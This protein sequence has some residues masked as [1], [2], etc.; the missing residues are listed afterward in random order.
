MRAFACDT[1]ENLLFFENT[2]CLRCGHQQRFAVPRMRLVALAAESGGTLVDG[3]VVRPC[4]NAQRVGC[5]WL[6]DDGGA[7][8]ASCRLTRTRPADDDPEALA[9]WA[10]AEASKRRLLFQLFD[11]HMPVDGRSADNP[12]GLTFDLLSSRDQPVTT[13]H[14]DGVVTLDLAEGNDAHREALRAQL[15]EPYRTMLG[16]FRHETGHY[17]WEV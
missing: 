9:A 2:L 4:A 10:D 6:V 3:T 5:N 13:G 12:T 15:A 11:Q 16:H 1:C 14:A 8:C 17:Y 7:F